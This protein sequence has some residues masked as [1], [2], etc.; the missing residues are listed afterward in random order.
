MICLRP[1]T[2]DV[3]ICIE[4]QL[5]NFIAYPSQMDFHVNIELQLAKFEKEI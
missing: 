5:K 3:K 1:W 2:T 4:G